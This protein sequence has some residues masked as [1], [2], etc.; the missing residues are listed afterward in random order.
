MGP[1]EFMTIIIIKVLLIL[2]YYW[3]ITKTIMFCNNNNNNNNKPTLK[4]CQLPINRRIYIIIIMYKIILIICYCMMRT[5]RAYNHYG[6][7]SVI[8]FRLFKKKKH[9]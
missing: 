2:I 4:I 7:R 8:T 6:G 1:T 3:V 5:A 9:I